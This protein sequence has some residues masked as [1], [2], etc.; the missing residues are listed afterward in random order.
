M[1]FYEHVHIDTNNVNYNRKYIRQITCIHVNNT[2]LP[3][4]KKLFAFAIDYVK[5]HIHKKFLSC[6]TDNRI[7]EVYV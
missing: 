6:I 4:K 5:N 1:I 7:L 3:H 2:F